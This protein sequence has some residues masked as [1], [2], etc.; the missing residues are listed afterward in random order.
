MSRQQRQQQLREIDPW[1]QRLHKEHP[2]LFDLLTVEVALA[3]FGVAM[4]LKWNYSGC[5]LGE[6]IRNRRVMG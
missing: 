2:V 6:S 5:L 3:L 4:L 1:L